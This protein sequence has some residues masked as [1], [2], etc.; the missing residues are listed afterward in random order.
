M[1][2]QDVRR[3]VVEGA[4]G[5]IR[6]FREAG[7]SLARARQA[8]GR[9]LPWTAEGGGTS[10]RKHHGLAALS[11]YREAEPTGCFARHIPSPIGFQPAKAEA[12]SLQTRRK[13][14]TAVGRRAAAWETM[15]PCARPKRP[16]G[17]A[18]R[19]I[20]PNGREAEIAQGGGAAKLRLSCFG[21][22]VSPSCRLFQAAMLDR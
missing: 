22:P 20:V 14:R 11:Q 10:K 15:W 17:L 12:T 6:R 5:E 9:P 18:I 13:T 2:P 8:R 1:Y 19:L 3:P 4:S 7:G 16:K 21:A